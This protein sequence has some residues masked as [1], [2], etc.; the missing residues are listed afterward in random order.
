[1]RVPYCDQCGKKMQE[2]VTGQLAFV[3]YSVEVNRSVVPLDFCSVNCLNLFFGYLLP[4][5]SDN[6]GT[7]T[8]VM[9]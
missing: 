7:A 8:E 3:P 1:M 9:P 2:M 5:A 6:R 4:A